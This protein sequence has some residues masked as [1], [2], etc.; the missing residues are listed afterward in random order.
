MFI[1]TLAWRNLWRNFRRTGIAVGAMTLALVV[2]LLYSGIVVGMV[3][4]MEKDATGYELG[5]VQI[6]VEGYPSKPSIYS[7]IPHDEEIIGELEERGYRAT[8]RLFAGG[9]AASGE[10]SAGALFVGLDP[11]RDAAT[12]DLDAAVARGEW[13]DDADPHGVVV[14]GGLARVLALEVGDELLVLSQA[15][16]GSMANELFEVRGVL[17]SVAAGMG[18]AGILMTENTFRELMV[19]PH[20]SHR[21]LVRRPAGVSLSEADEVVRQIVSE[22]EPGEEG[23]LEVM[24]WKEVNPFLAQYMDTAAGAVLI[25][26]LI[27]YLA[28]G[29]LILNAMLM[30]VF[31]RI[32]EFGVLKAIGYSPAQVMGMMVAEALMQAAIASVLGV[33]LAAP[34]MWYLQVVGIDVGRLSGM[35]MAGLTMPAVIRGEYTVGTCQV[36]VLMLYVISFI[37]VLYPAAK[38]AWISPVEAMHHQ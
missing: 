5:D 7:L 33:L 11:V 14:G 2:E 23:P 6:V 15:A 27:I 9:L 21:V 32:R 31:E 3:N 19:L 36:P 38:A 25:L 34:G 17:L 26:Y 1:L 16:D 35:A 13:L 18:R 20:G 28:V 37:A 4:G 10:L 24:T 22:Q 8:G 29:I 30:A 12:M